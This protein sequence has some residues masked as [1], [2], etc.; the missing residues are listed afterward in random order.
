[1]DPA[2][3]VSVNP[4]S[5][6]RFDPGRMAATAGCPAPAAP[7]RLRGGAADPPALQPIFPI[8]TI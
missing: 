8:G 3:L 7:F 5:K 6:G 2:V 4:F 1:M